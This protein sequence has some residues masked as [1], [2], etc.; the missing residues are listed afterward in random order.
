MYE[1]D[2]YTKEEFEKWKKSQ[3]S[4]Y[5]QQVHDEFLKTR[6]QKTFYKYTQT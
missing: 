5:D 1:N 2:Q 3:F 6:Y 4:G